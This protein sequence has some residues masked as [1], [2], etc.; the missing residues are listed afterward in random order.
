MKSLSKQTKKSK[1]GIKNISKDSVRVLIILVLSV[2]LFL[3]GIASCMSMM[4]KC[5]I[6]DRN[7]ENIKSD[8][9]N[10][11][12]KNVVLVLD[13]EDFYIEGDDSVYTKS[14]IDEYIRVSKQ[15]L[16]YYNIDNKDFV[17]PLNE[18]ETR[19]II[20]DFGILDLVLL[21]VGLVL[22][23]L[24]Y[25]K[26][27]WQKALFWSFFI[28]IELYFCLGL[29]SALDVLYNVEDKFSL[30]FFGKAMLI[31]LVM[32]VHSIIVYIC[33]KKNQNYKSVIRKPLKNKRSKKV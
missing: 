13:N 21:F 20:L 22:G 5:A 25:R 32:L 9:L 18:S 16:Y 33:E 8:I 24:I 10:G 29:Y 27:K 15:N 1:R 2:T 3:W 23:I 6:L 11:K 12:L 7:A 30:I 31:A 14:D 26:K 28:F 19:K 4:L 17:A